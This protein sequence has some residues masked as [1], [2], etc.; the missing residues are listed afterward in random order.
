M[1]S[2]IFWPTALFFIGLGL[3]GILWSGCQP[4]PSARPAPLKVGVAF[5]P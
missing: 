3:L 2:K 4:A 5:S 1:K